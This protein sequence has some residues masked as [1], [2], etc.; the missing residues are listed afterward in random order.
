MAERAYVEARRILLDALTALEPQLD[1]L[2][3]V[4]AQ[5]AHIHI[6]GVPAP[7]VDYTTDADIAIDP[8]QL[9]E[10]PEIG[11]SLKAAGL[12]PKEDGPGIWLWADRREE[13]GPSVDLLVPQSLA[14]ARGHRAARLDGHSRD[15]ARYVHGI[16]A[17][18]VD[19]S[20]HRIAALD[21][22]DK[23]SYE[24]KVAGPAAILIAKLVKISERSGTPRVEPKDGYEAFRLMQ[25][26][27]Q[28]IVE[29]WRRAL[30]SES[31]KVVAD[32]AIELLAQLFGAAGGAGV[33]LAVKYVGE[34]EDPRQ[35]RLSSPV[36]ANQVVAALRRAS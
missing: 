12:M 11:A 31:S 36:L 3:L 27:L 22:M 25:L 10:E 17:A 24:L 8:A 4:G 7:V 13:D 34:F 19:W 9:D 33:D 14:R 15:A 21:P 32:E 5:A 16:E 20:R 23:R 30:A 18:L 26:P 2:I 1:A 28:R 35:M 6:D 29:G